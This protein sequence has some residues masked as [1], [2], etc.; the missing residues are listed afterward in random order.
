MEN[1]WISNQWSWRCNYENLIYSYNMLSYNSIYTLKNTLLHALNLWKYCQIEF[2]I[3]QF[4]KKVFCHK[5]NDLFLHLTSAIYHLDKER[6]TEMDIL[7]KSAFP[8]GIPMN[9]DWDIVYRTHIL[10]R[11]FLIFVKLPRF[12]FWIPVQFQLSIPCFCIFSEISYKFQF[13][14]IS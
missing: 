7:S 5:S 12:S 3:K 8:G 10:S 14:I 6:N 9:W 2:L 1:Y 4:F 13:K 11:P